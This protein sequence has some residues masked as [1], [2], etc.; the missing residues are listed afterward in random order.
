[1]NL[2]NK[3][4][5]VLRLI[6]GWKVE[7][8]SGDDPDV[9]IRKVALDWF[10]E[11]FQENVVEVNKAF[12]QFRLSEGLMRL[13]NFI[14]NDFFSWL[15]EIVKPAYGRSEEHTSELQSRGHLVCRLLLE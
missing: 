1:M 3:M 7:D 14:W 2:K 9:Q 13:Y 4:L 11:K 8:I 6:K 12:D 5:N 10:D 15:L